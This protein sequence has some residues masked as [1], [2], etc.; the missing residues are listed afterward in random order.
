MEFNTPWNR[1]KNNP[2]R[3]EGEYLV[4]KGSYIPAKQQIEN[5]MLAG[6]RLEAYRR[7]MYDLGPDDEDDGRTD[8][9][10]RPN[11][12]LADAHQDLVDA[13]ARIKAQGIAAKRKNESKAEERS[14]KAPE[15]TEKVDGDNGE[16]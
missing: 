5:L 11:Y 4:E 14:Q 7:E 2:E 3:N 15:A 12:D 10:R 16:K 8:P 13:E 1:K 9:T 6:S